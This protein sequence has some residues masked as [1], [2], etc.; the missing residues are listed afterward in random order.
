MLSMWVQF[1]NM[2]FMCAALDS[3]DRI[4]TMNRFK[5]KVVKV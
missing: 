3:T 1:K 5:I 2:N 4:G